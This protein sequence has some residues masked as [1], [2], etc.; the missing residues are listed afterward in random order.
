MRSLSY[1]CRVNPGLEYGG[2]FEYSKYQILK[3]IPN[4]FKPKTFYLKEKNTT[5][6]PLPFPF[7]VKPDIG[8]RGKN[9]ELILNQ[10]DWVN[11]K[12][13]QNLILQ[14]Y[15]D[16]P[17]EFGLFYV[18]NP[19]TNTAEILSITGKEFFKV[20]GD[21]K[22]TLKEFIEGSP[23]VSHRMEYFQEKFASEW[24]RIL[25]KNEEILIEPIGNHNRGTKFLNASHLITPDLTAAV[26]EV[27]RHIQGFNYGRFDVKTKSEEDLKKG[28]FVI[29]EVNGTNSEPT[30]VYDP[31]FS[32]L[33]AYKE[34]YRHMRMQYL[35]A[36]KH[37]RTYSR[38]AF[39]TIFSKK[40]RE[41]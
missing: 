38:K 13:D 4:R 22:R 29:L 34:V 28:N 7:V 39:W 10:E 6:L 17:Y 27:A 35:I 5:P 15:I 36:K 12:I 8:E 26:E 3:Q 14:E 31:S 23:R 11:Y 16:Y 9:V 37:P 41:I 21:G 32:I 2:L 30:H 20:K 25:D 33:T 1:Y 19:Q 40:I 18:Q 24:D